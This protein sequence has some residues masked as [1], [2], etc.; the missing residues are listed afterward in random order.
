MATN[1]QAG[2][3]EA[4]T[5]DPAAFVHQFRAKRHGAGKDVKVVITQRDSETG[6][7][8]TTL[9]V[10]LAMCWDQHGWSGEEKGTTDPET[11]L[12]TF[13]DLPPH[14]ALIMD[15][16][17]ELDARRAMS[18]QNVEFSKKWM[19]MRTRQIDSILTLP[20]ATALD[21]RLKEL[22]DLRLHV[23]KRGSAK[24]YRI[25]VDDRSHEVD[26]RFKEEFHWPDVSQTPEF[27]ALDREKQEDLDETAQE[28]N[29]QDQQ[30]TPKEVVDEIVQRG[31]IEEYIDQ[32][33]TQEYISADFI[34]GRHGL[35]PS[36]AKQAKALLK[37]EVDRDVL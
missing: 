11:F 6:G 21:V 27:Q 19:K 23:T 29:E 36:R 30:P 16:A 4:L 20:T 22:A 1:Q 9:A 25:K 14:S 31:A 2:G 34:G 8:K 15:E 26:E 3:Q 7:G 33:G 18:D 35:Q 12:S 24:V 32:N 17:E 5:P 13:P 10:W 28:E 37:A